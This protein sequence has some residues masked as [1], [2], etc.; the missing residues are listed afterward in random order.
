MFVAIHGPNYDPLTA[1]DIELLKKMAG[2]V[3]GVKLMSYATLETW[4]AVDEALHPKLW[5][6]R[7]VDLAHIANLKAIYAAGYRNVIVEFYNEPNNKV[8]GFTFDGKPNIGVFVAMY[9]VA[10]STI[11]AACPEWQIGFTGLSPQLAPYIWWTDP[12]V[13]PLLAR[14]H[15][16]C[17]HAYYLNSP[18]EAEIDLQDVLAYCPDKTIVLSEVACTAGENGPPPDRATL[19]TDYVQLAKRFAEYPRVMAVVFWIVDG[20]H[21]WRDAGET[22][23]EQMASALGA[24]RI[25]I[26]EVIEVVDHLADFMRNAWERLGVRVNPDDSF[27]KEGV[28]QARE[29][30]VYIFPTPSPD[31]NYYVE[32]EGYYVSQTMPPMHCPV[33]NPADV[34]MGLPSPFLVAQA[35]ANG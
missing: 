15:V 4:R 23:D 17:G 14:A 13:K 6:V 30:G 10:E 29:N 9:E 25:P 2:G 32:I 28:K 34:K 19:A 12:R 16:V 3:H 31:G 18:N 11:V 7:L 24:L 8:E 27:F 22:F 20:T 5:I 1:E 26:E 21:E 35:G 33:D